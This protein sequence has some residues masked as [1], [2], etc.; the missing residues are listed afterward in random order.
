ML[1]SAW[2]RSRGVRTVV[3]AERGDDGNHDE[4]DDGGLDVH[5]GLLLLVLLVVLEQV[6]VRL[7]LE[8]EV[9][10]GRERASRGATKNS[11]SNLH[12]A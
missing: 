2:N 11:G 8:E 1:Q 4:R 5:L 12:A 3:G 10:D 7:E 9:C 6:G